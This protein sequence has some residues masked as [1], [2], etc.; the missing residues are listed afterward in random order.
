[1][2]G[3]HGKILGRSGN[4]VAAVQGHSGRYNWSK[5]CTVNVRK[6][7]GK[8]ANYADGPLGGK[9]G[10]GKPAA[11]GS[12]T[13]NAG[14]QNLSVAAYIV[15]A[16]SE[17]AAPQHMH[18]AAL[19]AHGGP[20]TLVPLLAAV[21]GHGTHALEAALAVEA[22][23]LGAGQLLREGKGGAG[24]A[25]LVSRAAAG[26]VESSC[27]GSRQGAYETCAV[28]VCAGSSSARG[29]CTGGLRMSRRV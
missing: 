3:W 11:G 17:R 14:P 27:K 5:Q 7:S 29:G 4:R 13:C 9:P 10:G 16:V 1:M 25:R 18:A 2:K 20:A 28:E 21:A 24:R 12:C 6:H 15:Q 19:L 23:P 8:G 26:Q 22:A